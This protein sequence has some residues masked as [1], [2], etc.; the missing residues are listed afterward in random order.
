[1]LEFIYYKVAKRD[2]FSDIVDAVVLIILLILLV[3]YVIF[4]YF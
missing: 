2:Y 3:K 4:P 1:M